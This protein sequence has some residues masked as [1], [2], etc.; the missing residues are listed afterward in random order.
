ME[1]VHFT[2]TRDDFWRLQLYASFRRSRRN[3]LRLLLIGI[4]IVLSLIL[5]SLPSLSGG[6]PSILLMAFSLLAG[7]L[8]FVILIFG[9]AFLLMWLRA[10]QANKMLG[11]RGV[12]V[13]NISA[14]GVQQRNELSNSTTSWRAFKS[15]EED[16]HNIYF[17]LENP[18][19][20]F[21]ALLIPKR[22][23]ESPQ[24]AER[25][26]ERARGY[27][28]EQSAQVATAHS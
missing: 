5:M 23:F 8:A 15:I 27:W 2:L 10:S 13:I 20:L 25:F 1:E 22:A 26:I 21:M 7:L 6:V 3:R 17:A 12:N 11:K 28:R 9:L 16:K 18:G 19:R 14:Q 4:L 24:V